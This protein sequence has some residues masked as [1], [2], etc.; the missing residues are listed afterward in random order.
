MARKPPAS[1]LTFIASQPGAKVPTPPGKL[2]V[3]GMSLWKDITAAYQFEDRASYEALFQACCAADRAEACRK[4]IDEDGECIRSGKIIRDH[5]LLKHEIAARAFVVRT[6]G[7]LGL[8]LEPVRP[9][10]GRPPGPQWHGS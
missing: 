7:R 1:N 8:D 3:T 4:Q 10:P 6:L 5:P 9:G 2:A